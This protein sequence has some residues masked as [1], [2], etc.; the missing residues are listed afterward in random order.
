M[1][2]FDWFQR[3][4]PIADAATLVDYLDSRAAYL[5][6]TSIFDF[7]R[8]CT[9]MSFG[10]LMKDQTFIEAIEKSR[11]SSYP[12]G[13]S[14]VGEM[15]HGVLR[16]EASGT[17]PLAEAL[18]HAAFAAFDR[19]SVPA[20]LGTEAWTNA[21]ADLGQ[22]VIG[23]GLHSPKA[24]KDIPLALITQIFKQLPISEKIRGDD[25]EIVV[26]QLRMN[27]IRMHEDFTCRA[28]P[29]A[30]VRELGLVSTSVPSEPNG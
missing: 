26:N 27:L 21:R 7:A 23:I 4:P 20:T 19:Y 28:D 2:I 29:V 12:L 5:V 10:A 30:L 22:R 1:G 6:Q 13:L 18:R 24:V 3:P 16:P 11:W 9:G 15:V 8:A 17:M 25:Q 14:I